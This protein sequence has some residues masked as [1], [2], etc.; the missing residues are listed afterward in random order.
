MK[1]ALM[2]KSIPQMSLRQVYP[3]IVGRMNLNTCGDPDC[4]NFG[5]AP[6]F[7]HGA[8]RGPGAAQRRL[9]ASV[10]N[11]ALGTGLG[12]YKMESPGDDKLERISQFFEY[13]DDPHAWQDG[14]VMICQHLRGNGDCGVS[15][16]ILSNQHFSDEFDRLS[17]Q[18]GLLDGPR[19]GACGTRYLD[20]PDEFA[21]N[22]ANGKAR[23]SRGKTKPPG[24][25]VVHKPCRG[26]NR[27]RFTV[28]A[29]HCRQRDRKENIAIL[30][31]LANG[32]GINDLRRLL[33]P[34]K[35][36]RAVGVKHIY[37]R[38]FWLERTLL[39]YEQVQLK[40]WRSRLAAK[41]RFRHTRIAHDDVVLG[42]NWETSK[43]RRITALNCAVSA[44]VRS[45]YV[46]RA[47]V[48]FDPRVDPVR[49]I[50]ETFLGYGGRTP[51]LR[52]GYEQSKKTFTA[53]LLAFQRPSGR[54]DEAALF[55][56]AESVL[57][58][59]DQ[60]TAK[61]Y[62]RAGTEP[63]EAVRQE[64][65]TAR[66]KSWVINE[67]ANLFFN[68]PPNER[69]SRNTFNGIMTRDTYTKAA[70]LACLR[71]QVPFGKIT[72]ISEQEAAMARVVPHIFGEMIG[73]DRFEWH[74]V[75]FDK[76]AK[77]PET[78]RRTAL[79]NEAF[80]AFREENP[81]LDPWEALHLW[82]MSR[83]VPA[84][85][86]DADGNE[87]GA[88]PISNFASKA[89]PA[90]W[91]RSPV[92]VAGETNKVVGFPILSPR[93]RG[94][95]RR[96][97]MRGTIPPGPLREAITR[98]VINATVQPAATFCNAL[99]E[100]VSFAR[101]AGGRAARTGPSYINGACFNPRVLIAVLNIYRIYYNYF[102]LRQ[103][104]SP[105]NKHEATAYVPGGKKLVRVPGSD[106]EV[107]VPQERRLTPIL[108]T[109]AMRAGI[110]EVDR[111]EKA[112][113]LP[114]L[115]RILYQP[116]LFHGTP[117]WGKLQGR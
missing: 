106:I 39:A 80:R 6:D 61:A 24:I 69:D 88:F 14:R 2:V 96:L 76:A 50:E 22:G 103:Y 70:S 36:R 4:G 23:T 56:A 116:W 57:R 49:F 95:Y 53:P 13:E 98:R 73:E 58:L 42:C 5:V 15:F 11:P 114:D 107:E 17:S 99:R 63:P 102:E 29:E 94:D 37:D 54:F 91:L 1:G 111:E 83:L 101:R 108:R 68:F 82:T 100:R 74:V 110:H 20:R 78:V 79:Y 16:L 26:D 113:S 104:V 8:F 64:M 60:T 40:L 19:C 109:P 75:T 12:R 65:L 105:L 51:A 31:H 32:A 46:F 86:V 77:K 55:A 27:A 66:V 71:D 89:I 93:Y 97:G 35:G 92:Q 10:A 28:S 81:E 52:A 90:L 87:I 41:N 18:N 33:T 43:D 67:I 47:D 38:I 112:P 9:L 72:L 62:E 85:R 44:D 21:F 7:Q 115:S 84:L 45:G 25:R 30:R 117:L 59:F 34:E 3:P 48:D